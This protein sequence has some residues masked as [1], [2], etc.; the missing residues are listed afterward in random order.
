MDIIFEAECRYVSVIIAE[1]DGEYYWGSEKQHPSMW[2]KVTPAELIDSMNFLI[3]C[4]NE[5]TERWL[6]GEYYDAT[7][8]PDKWAEASSYIVK[9][10]EGV[11]EFIKWHKLPEIVTL[12]PLT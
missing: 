12:W 2:Q 4:E 6:R 11:I 1:K 9:L 5:G 7:I 10:Y 3:E 8:D